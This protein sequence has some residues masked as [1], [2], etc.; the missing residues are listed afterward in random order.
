MARGRSRVDALE[1]RLKRVNP[2]LRIECQSLEVRR[3]RVVALTGEHGGIINVSHNLKV[4][5]L[6]E[7]ANGFLA[8]KYKEDER[9][10]R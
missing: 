4:G 7:W 2:N 1:E 9:A 5:E 3:C 6:E 8:C 10:V